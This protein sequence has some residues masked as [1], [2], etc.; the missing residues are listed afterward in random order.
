MNRSLTKYSV[1]PSVAV[2]SWCGSVPNASKRDDTKVLKQVTA[3]LKDLSP[4]FPQGIE[5]ANDVLYYESFYVKHGETF[6]EVILQ[7]EGEYLLVF[8]CN[9]VVPASTASVIY[10]LASSTGQKGELSVGNFVDRVQGARLQTSIPNE[11][12]LLSFSHK[13]FASSFA[14]KIGACN[15]VACVVRQQ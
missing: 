13:H 11:R 6:R 12:L 15:V 2:G 10:H 14:P 3:L 8:K 5:C 1:A 4:K 9:N 7:T